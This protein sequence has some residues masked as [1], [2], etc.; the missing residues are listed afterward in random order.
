MKR[1]IFILVCAVVFLMSNTINADEICRIKGTNDTVEVF[2][3]NYDS[4]LN[5]LTITFSNDG[6]S[7]ANLTVS[8]KVTY[9][10]ENSTIRISKTYSDKHFAN[11]NGSSV[12]KMRIPNS[13][14]EN[15]RTYTLEDFE[16]VSLEGNKCGTN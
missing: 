1:I 12:L 7:A 6:Q 15:N 3:K 8:V 14:N 11:A 5:T 4:G 13:I 16:I 9:K 2:S 10:L